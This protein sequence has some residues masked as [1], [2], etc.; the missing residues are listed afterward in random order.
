MIRKCDD[1][2]F[3]KI[4]FIINEAAQAY[5]GVIPKD[6][7]HEPYMS[8]DELLHEIADG[9]VFWGYEEGHEFSGIMGIQDAK[10]V[11]LVRHAY[12]RTG[13]QRHGI[14]STLLDHLMNLTLRQMLIGTWADASW[15][16]RFYQKKGFR[17]VTKEEKNHLLRRYWSIPE[18]QVETSVV[19]AD[20]RWYAA[21]K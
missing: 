7:W 11:T 10:D 19:L 20:S 15:A 8:E 6:C 3:R 5:K 2:D 18:R 12:V 4:Y 1:T 13:R 17:L 14:G 16:I 21:H 9:V